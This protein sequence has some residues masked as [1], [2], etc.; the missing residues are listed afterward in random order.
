MTRQLSA[1]VV[2]AT[3]L[4]CPVVQAHTPPN[5]LTKEQVAAW[6]AQYEK[7][8]ETRDAAA[9]MPLFAANARY[10]EMPFQA[11][12]EGRQAIG[13]YWARVTADQKDIDFTSTVLAVEGNTGIATWRAELTQASSGAKVVLDGVFVLE[14]TTDRQCY[15][16]K[17]WWH[18]QVTPA[19][20]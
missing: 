12:F 10:R 4:L 3:I 9:A 15:D 1:L 7:A 6:L 11:A 17:E 20:K 18:V 14:F 8:W 19:A 5:A 2:A 16:L 13:D